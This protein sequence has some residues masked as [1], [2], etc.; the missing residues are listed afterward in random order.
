MI[1]LDPTAE[2]LIAQVGVRADRLEGLGDAL[3]HRL[4]D[5]LRVLGRDPP[6]RGD[7]LLHPLALGVGRRA[8]LG[9]VAALVEHPLLG[10]DEVVGGFDEVAG[11]LR[12]VGADPIDQPRRLRRPAQLL[13]P[14]GDVAI[15]FLAQLLCERIALADEVLGRIAVERGESLVEVGIGHPPT[16][17]AP[18]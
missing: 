8:Q 7:H 3:D 14:G 18:R 16:V 13:H 10:G 4:V 6:R 5:R 1:G 9:R 17:A 15:S 11:S 12:L 2:E